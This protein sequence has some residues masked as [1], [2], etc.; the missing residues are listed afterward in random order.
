[1]NR[2]GNNVAGPTLSLEKINTVPEAPAVRDFENKV[3]KQRQSQTFRYWTTQELEMLRNRYPSEGPVPIAKEINRKPAEVQD[4]AYKQGIKLNEPNLPKF[5][6][7]ADIDELMRRYPHED[8]IKLAKSLGRS[9]EMVWNKASKLRLKKADLGEG[10][11]RRHRVAKAGDIRWDVKGHYRV[12]VEGRR[13]WPLLHHENWIAVHG[14]IPPKHCV[15]FKDGDPR[16][17]EI[18]NLECLPLKDRQNRL[19]LWPPELQEVILLQREIQMQ[20]NH[21]AKHEQ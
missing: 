21:G 16:N 1:M 6:A 19:S 20:I 13:W 5:W 17:C 14:P 15:L 11:V 12:K 18:S 2:L 7:A 8:T 3:A 4:K 10:K 9:V